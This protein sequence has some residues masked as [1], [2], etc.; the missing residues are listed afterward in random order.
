LTYAVDALQYLINPGF[1]TDI[2]VSPEG[3][4]AIIAI[5]DAIMLIVSTYLFRQETRRLIA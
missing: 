5:F 1:K 4:I 2:G 3:D